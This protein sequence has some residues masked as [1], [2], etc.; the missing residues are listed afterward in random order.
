LVPK[1]PQGRT[2]DLGTN[3][4]AILVVVKLPQGWQFWYNCTNIATR[5]IFPRKLFVQKKKMAKKNS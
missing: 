5:M 1:L 2:K 4:A 3:I